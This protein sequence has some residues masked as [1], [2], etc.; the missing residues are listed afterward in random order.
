MTRICDGLSDGHFSFAHVSVLGYDGCSVA[1]SCLILC[2]PVDRSTPGFTV[3]HQLLEL[4]QTRPSS[5]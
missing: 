1:Q 5:Q 3:S 2:D 4:A